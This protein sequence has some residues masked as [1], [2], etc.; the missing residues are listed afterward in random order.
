MWWG[1]LIWMSWLVYYMKYIK[2]KMKIE[3]LECNSF[4]SLFLRDK[5]FAYY[6]RHCLLMMSKDVNVLWLTVIYH[7]YLLSAFYAFKPSLYCESR[8]NP[9]TALCL[10]HSGPFLSKRFFLISN[11]HEIVFTKFWASNGDS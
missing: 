1:L 10:P 8:M 5:N 2:D 9:A 11:M 3:A 6:Y 4:M 7:I